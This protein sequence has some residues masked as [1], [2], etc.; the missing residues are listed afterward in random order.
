M[1]EL[2]TFGVSFLAR[3][4]Q[5][6]MANAQADKAAEREMMYK[7]TQVQHSAAK[8]TRQT[9]LASTLFSI[10]ASII[11]ILATLAII[12][13]PKIIM[14]IDPSVIVQFGFYEAKE[15]FSLLGFIPIVPPGTDMEFQTVKGLLI[16]PMDTH[17]ISSIAGIY[18]GGVGRRR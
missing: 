3:A 1:T 12:V 5:S 2:I 6:H 4:I 16:T 13:L 7:M 17:L 18:F 10:T 8:D 9:M 15:G 11:A 14:L